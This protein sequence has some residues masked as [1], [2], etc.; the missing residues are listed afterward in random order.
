MP[1]DSLYQSLNSPGVGPPPPSEEVERIENFILAAT[2]SAQP[3]KDAPTVLEGHSKTLPD[4]GESQEEGTKDL[5]ISLPP[6]P[7]YGT[8]GRA[9]K[10]WTNYVELTISGPKSA[11][12]TRAEQSGG[13]KGKGKGGSGKPPRADKVKAQSEASHDLYKYGVS[14]DPPE[15]GYGTVRI[16]QLLL[17]DE[18]LQRFKGS[19]VSDFKTF[20][21][22]RNNILVDD[23]GDLT[24]LKEFGVRFRHEDQDAPADNA[25]KYRV[26]VKLQRVLSVATL[27]KYL[28]SEVPEVRYGDKEEMLQALNIFLNHYVKVKAGGPNVKTIGSNRTFVLGMPPYVP[29]DACVVLPGQLWKGK[30]RTSQIRDM[31]KFAVRKPDLNAA[32]IVG[33]GL[34]IVGAS[35]KNEHLTQAGFSVKSSLITVPSRVLPSPILEYFRGEQ[36]GVRDGGWKMTQGKYFAQTAKPRITSPQQGVQANANGH[37]W[38]YVILSRSGDPN[39]GIAGC[40]TLYRQTLEQ[41]GLSLAPPATLAGS[42]NNCRLD[43]NDPKLHHERL[44]DDDTATYNSIKYL[45]DVVYGVHTVCALRSK[46]CDSQ[47]WDVR[48][49][50][51]MKI[52]IKLGGVNHRVSTSNLGLVAEGKTMIVGIDVTHPSPDQSAATPSVAAMVASRGAELGQ[53]PGEVAVQSRSRDEMVS[54]L[55]GMMRRRLQLWR[56]HNGGRLPENII[57]YR[58]GVSE[59]QY[60]LVLR[61]EV[62]ELDRA[63]AEVYG[64]EEEEEAVPAP[65]VAV[66]IVGK[67]HHTRFYPAV[68]GDTDRGNARPGTV[69]DRGVTE[70]RVWD[71]YLQ[72]HSALQ[73][74]ARPA[75]Y[76]VIRDDIFNPKGGSGGGGRG[77]AKRPE[78]SPG[79]SPAKPKAAPGSPQGPVRGKPLMGAM[80]QGGRGRMGSIGGVLHGSGGSPGGGGSGGSGARNPADE[81]EALTHSLC[82]VFGRATK[83]V[84][85][86]TPTYYADILCERA[87]CYMACDAAVN[88]SAAD[89]R[90]LLDEAQ[91]R[92]IRDGAERA[93]AQGLLD[94]ARETVRERARRAVRVHENITDE[95][96]YI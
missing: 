4:S 43:G 81:L 71:F 16:I 50:L 14:I 7:A 26:V 25:Q 67:R 46:I 37:P 6:R 79:T 53:W 3:G 70:A 47:K 40:R 94:E 18:E 77:G 2:A 29:A 15:S 90:S 80:L 12:D 33:S 93:R 69:V 78:S 49:Y 64:E 95:M 24:V 88:P 1:A 56:A 75:H 22:S 85:I 91:I 5:A 96:F 83:A 44:D 31:I 86:V 42:K 61:R 76:V 68:E 73:G 21:V 36:P 55:R 54:E 66:V 92:R 28:T 23:G 17:E 84:S 39:D 20:L 11:Q 32:S 89:Q 57:V 30:L 34:D 63:C 35:D 45:G 8:Q 48:S 10:L 38:T 52:N 62:P 60:R 41:T 13:G 58:D 74:T 19:I 82:Y 9:T 65:R 51:A 27:R 87:R 59:G 72:S